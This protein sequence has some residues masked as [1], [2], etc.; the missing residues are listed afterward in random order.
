MGDH[1]PATVVRT[2]LLG[3]ASS[4]CSYAAPAL[5]KSLF[6]RGADFTSAMVFMVASTNLVIELGVVLWLLIGWQ[7][8][9]AEFV[10][11]AIMITLFVLVAP[12]VFPAAEL[13]GA[14]HRLEA[15]A[16]AQ[17][18]PGGSDD[19]E[20]EGLGLGARLRSKARW[21]DAAGYAISDV[22]MLRREL[23]IGYLVAGVLAI[24]VPSSVYNVVFVSGTAPSPSWRT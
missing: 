9:L 18:R 23:L 11:G 12:L 1:K 6:Q 2:G 20:W 15:R 4:S 22:T 5:A 19:A 14:R 7:F 13:E 3:A 16:A 17:G 8:A 24:A 10:G 21:A